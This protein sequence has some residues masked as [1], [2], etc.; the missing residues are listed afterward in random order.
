MLAVSLVFLS[1]GAWYRSFGIT[2][3]AGLRFVT[4]P[5][6]EA[7]VEPWHSSRQKGE[8]L[9]FL[10]GDRRVAYGSG[11]PGYR[12]LLA[13]AQA[14]ATVTVGY[15]P[16]SQPFGLRAHAIEVYTISV[17]SQPIRTYADKIAEEKRGSVSS[18]LFGGAMLAMAIFLLRRPRERLLTPR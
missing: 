8:L 9:S 17:G 12:P 13:A 3:E 10:V 15:G 14:G 5:A 6:T 16:V 4:G 2:P 7:R 18:I 11:Q 1:M